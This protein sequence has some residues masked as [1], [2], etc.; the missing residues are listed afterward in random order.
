MKW[1]AGRHN[2]KVMQFNRNYL[3]FIKTTGARASKLIYA[4]R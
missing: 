1:P 4:R 2:A 3:K